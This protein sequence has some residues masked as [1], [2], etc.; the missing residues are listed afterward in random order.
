MKYISTTNTPEYPGC[1]MAYHKRA[2]KK[3]PGTLF[4]P[5]IRQRI[6]VTNI[7]FSSYKPGKKKKAGLLHH[8][9]AV[10]GGG[11]KQ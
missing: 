3:I 4:L 9:G 11:I 1:K 6:A 7:G 10:D 5:C 8:T 2:G